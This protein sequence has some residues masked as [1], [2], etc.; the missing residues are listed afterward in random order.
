MNATPTTSPA[1][2]PKRFGPASRRGNGQLSALSKDRILRLR[3]E[4]ADPAPIPSLAR[5]ISE[6]VRSQN[7][8]QSEQELKTSVTR[9]LT[10][11]Q[12]E[13][14]SQRQIAK[15]AGLTWGTWLR[16]RDGL[17]D[18][19]AWLPKLRAALAGVQASA[20]PGAGVQAS[21]CVTSTFNL[22]P[23]TSSPHA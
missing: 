2:W 19:V 10:H 22:Q 12:T 18:P 21:A 11:A 20:C 4:L 6:A 3:A 13:Q 8:T 23:A 17:A 1:R 9:L 7:N 16:I 14:L 5:L 15:R